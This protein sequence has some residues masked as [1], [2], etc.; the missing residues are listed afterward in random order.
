MCNA[1]RK[2]C[3]V[4]VRRKVPIHTSA[5]NTMTALDG[6]T[7]SR[8]VYFP[9][10]RFEFQQCPAMRIAGSRVPLSDGAPCRIYCGE[11]AEDTR[12]SDNPI[13]EW[14]VVVLC[15]RPGDAE[16]STRINLHRTAAPLSYAPAGATHARLSLRGQ[17]AQKRARARALSHG[18]TQRDTEGLVLLVFRS[19]VSRHVVG[20]RV[21]P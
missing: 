2:T 9:P 17:P 14:V 15:L 11:P 7:W 20:D 16:T 21:R 3:K 12:V 1:S 19:G 4:H 10:F 13:S 6:V 18:C 8:P 5:D